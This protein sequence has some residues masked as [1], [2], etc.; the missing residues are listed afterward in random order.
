MTPH[1]I[2]KNASIANLT[3]T[4]ENIHVAPLVLSLCTCD[5]SLSFKW[6]FVSHALC[7]LFAFRINGKNEHALTLVLLRHTRPKAQAFL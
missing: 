5:P 4:C 6:L 1:L 3:V 7:V 2:I